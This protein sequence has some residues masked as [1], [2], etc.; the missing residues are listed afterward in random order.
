MQDYMEKLRFLF[1]DLIFG[2]KS[3][4][5]RTIRYK[6]QHFRLTIKKGFRFF[7]NKG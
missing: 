6:F 2:E 4:L 5:G 3:R 1:F 7:E